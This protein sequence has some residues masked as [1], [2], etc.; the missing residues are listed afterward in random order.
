MITEFITLPLLAMI[1]VGTLLVMTLQ[2]LVS[3]FFSPL[4]HVPGP[5]AARFS[6]YWYMKRV[7]EGSFHKLNIQLHRQHGTCE[8]EL[9]GST[10]CQ[11]ER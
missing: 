7:S 1:A 5:M 10:A 8:D 3:P 11:W 4:R 6:R 2:C 9:S